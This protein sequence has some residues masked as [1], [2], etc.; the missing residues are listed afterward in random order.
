MGKRQLFAGEVQPKLTSFRA[1]PEA[2][3]TPEVIEHGVDRT[4]ANRLGSNP[5]KRFPTC[6]IKGSGDDPTDQ[7]GR[8]Q[9]LPA[10]VSAC[11]N[12]RRVAS[13]L[14]Q[15]HRFREL[16]RFPLCPP[17]RLNFPRP[18]FASGITKRSALYNPSR[19]TV[20]RSDSPDGLTV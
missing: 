10:P 12:D 15:L 3:F 2:L 5:A 6:G 14:Q 8:A 17:V 11:E 16:H 4:F 13:I 19:T 20:K 18:A 1:E 9:H 7:A